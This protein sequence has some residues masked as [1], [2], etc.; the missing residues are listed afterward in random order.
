MI[1]IRFLLLF[2]LLLACYPGAANAGI[3]RHILVPVVKTAPKV[4]AKVT[5]VTYKV[6]KAI[7]Y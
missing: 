3:I 6:T 2:F 5:V 1:K 7:V 4:I